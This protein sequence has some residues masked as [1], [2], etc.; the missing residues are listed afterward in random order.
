MTV[1]VITAP[2][3]YLVGRQQADWGSIDQFVEDHGVPCWTTDSEVAG[4]QL[5]EAAGRTCYMSFK[6]PRPGGNKAYLD[7]ILEVGHGSVLEHAAWNFII[8]GI[9]RSLSHELVRHRAGWS[10]SQLSQRYVD[11]SDVA[12]V[13]PPELLSLMADVEKQEWKTD[14]QQLREYRELTA[15]YYQWRDSC[16]LSLSF[17]KQMAD[18]LEKYL[19]PF[20]TALSVDEKR[21]LRKRV[22]QT[23][24]SVLPNCTETRIFCTANA[25]SLRHFLELRC[26]RFADVEIR[27]LAAALWEMLVLEAPNL[28]GDYEKVVLA[29]G[30]Y[31]LQTK[32]RKV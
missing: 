2:S 22:R 5:C 27:R 7:H 28:F 10:Y 23:A 24:R 13:C 6:A 26:S 16:E 18:S 31:E 30:S 19:V 25:R 15:P 1:K 17:Y 14:E 21:E 11:E 8:T 4:E 12:F 20:P 9:S 32:S 29:D 3:V